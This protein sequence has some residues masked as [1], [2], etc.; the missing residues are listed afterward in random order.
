MIG[1]ILS[2]VAG[3]AMSLQGVFNARLAD[4]VGVYESNAFVHGTAFALALAVMFAFGNGGLSNLGAANKIYWLGGV[5][6]IVITVTVM[7]A[8]GDLGPAFAVSVILISQL[9]VAAVID[10]FGLFG[11]EQAPFGLSKWLGMG[12]MIAGVVVF[13]VKV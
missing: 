9:L 13:K 10:A 7:L 4:K 5:L 3:A 2:I 1:M 11:T 6:G 12:L 8:I